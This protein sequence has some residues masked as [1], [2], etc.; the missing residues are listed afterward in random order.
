MDFNFVGREINELSLLNEYVRHLPSKI[1]PIVAGHLA[2]LQNASDVDQI[3]AIK[4]VIDCLRAHAATTFDEFIGY[5]A[6]TVAISLIKHPKLLQDKIALISHSFGYSVCINHWNKD[7][8]KVNNIIIHAPQPQRIHSSA[9][10]LIRRS[11]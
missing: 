6:F 7:L 8:V 10:N 2:K 11:L 9:I 3:V 5:V 1:A 4:S